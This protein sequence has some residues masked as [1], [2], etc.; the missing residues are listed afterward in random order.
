[1]Y[2]FH[3]P[4][5]EDLIEFFALCYFHKLKKVFA[6]PKISLNCD[7]VNRVHHIQRVA[8][9]NKITVI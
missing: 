5:T 4:K 3:S 8:I 9:P 7:V 1:M 6:F 2:V